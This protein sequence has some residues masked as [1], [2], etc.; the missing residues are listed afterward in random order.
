MTNIQT[1]YRQKNKNKL[2]NRKKEIT[3]IQYYINGL[4]ADI[5]Q[6][7]LLSGPNGIGKTSLLEKII[8]E[9][10]NN[11]YITYID[12][13]KYNNPFIKNM[14]EHII[15]KILDKTI[16]TIISNKNTSDE[17]K[18]K[19]IDIKNNENDKIYEISTIT[20][21]SI[22]KYLS[23]YENLKNQTFNLAQKIIE[24]EENVDGHVI[25]LENIEAIENEIIEDIINTT[26]IPKKNTSY[27]YSCNLNHKLEDMIKHDQ[28][29]VEIELEKFSLEELEEYIE[30][31][32]NIKLSRE[33]LK[34]FA[35]KTHSI[36]IYVNSFLNLLDDNR[37]YDKDEI[38]EIYENSIDQIHTRT[39][40]TY[41]QLN[42]QEKEI[43]NHMLGEEYTSW[44]ELHKKLPFNKGTLT[45]YL[46]T[47][48]NK[49]IIEKDK[50]RYYIKDIMLKEYLK[51]N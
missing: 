47:L 10:P 17:I 14:D 31:N 45:K 24:N 38:Q 4:K 7:I 25:I 28:K 20:G 23:F 16:K 42:V 19:L 11:Y 34:R 18:E 40:I 41:S 49:S 30:N 35:D 33:A 46:K 37:L 2:Y 22:S 32:S 43:L 36:P 48:L 12:L 50:R 13:E 1:N 29:I 44:T 15:S 5:S 26:K 8:K 21:I 39:I 3:Q 51:N 6:N 27:I 9:N